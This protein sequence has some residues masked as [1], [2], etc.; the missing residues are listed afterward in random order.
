MKI[1]STVSMAAV[2]LGVTAMVHSG[3]VKAEIDGCPQ[4]ALE[5]DQGNQEACHLYQI[6][7]RGEAAPG[8]TLSGTSAIKGNSKSDAAL[9]NSKQNASV[10]K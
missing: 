9:L 8:S 3:T 1:I 5:C 6:G 7:C 2:L 10:A 4:L